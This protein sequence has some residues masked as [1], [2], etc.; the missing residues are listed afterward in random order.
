MKYMI[1]LMVLFLFL[2]LLHPYPTYA[3]ASFSNANWE[4]DLEEEG[5]E[6]DMEEIE[7]RIIEQ[8]N[9]VLYRLDLLV[10]LLAMLFGCLCASIFSSFW[11]MRG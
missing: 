5:E 1:K 11:R 7:E 6:A 3:K 8:Y 9:A 2:L 4:E 10:S